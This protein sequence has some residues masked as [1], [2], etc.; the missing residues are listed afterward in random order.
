[1]PP[2]RPSV[3]SSHWHQLTTDVFREAKNKLRRHRYTDQTTY[4]VVARKSS[5]YTRAC[6]LK[7]MV[8]MCSYAPLMRSGSA[9]PR[10]TLSADITACQ[11]SVAT[12]E[13]RKAAPT[14]VRSREIVRQH[15]VHHRLYVCRLW[16]SCAVVYLR[17]SNHV[18][19]S[20]T[21]LEDVESASHIALGEL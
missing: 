7:S 6:G 9:S 4:S 13:G 15:R 14:L 2:A 8:S 12:M 11:V 3:G 5:R 21:R 10:S 1:M 19:R 18:I 17:L 16:T 20:M